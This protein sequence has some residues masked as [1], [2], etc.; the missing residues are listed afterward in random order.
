[1][2]R[3]APARG[4]RPTHP[5]LPDWLATLLHRFGLDHTQRTDK[6]NGTDAALTNGQEAR[7]ATR[8]LA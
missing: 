3:A 4:G 5:E 2:N 6:Q 1:M 7:V 8:I